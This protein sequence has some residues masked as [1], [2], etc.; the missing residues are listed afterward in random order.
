MAC[1]IMTQF[2]SCLNLPLHDRILEL[3]K[4]IDRASPN[5]DLQAIFPQ[6]VSNIF[7]PYG[8]NGWNLRQITFETNRY[9]YQTLLSFLEPLGP[10]FRLCY[11]LLSDPQ[12]KYNL[13]INTLPIDLQITLERG[14]CPQFYADLLATDTQSMNVVALA[15]S[16][17]LYYFLI[18]LCSNFY[19]QLLF[20]YCQEF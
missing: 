2:Y 10:M 1:D 18:P 16:I 19:I 8:Q 4:L 13:P 7:A 6:L 12:L 11:K 9:E 14:R 5:K 17:L 20:C 15:L 3:T